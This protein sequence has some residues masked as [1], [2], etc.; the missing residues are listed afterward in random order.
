VFIPQES[1]PPDQAVD[2][3]PDLSIVIPVFNEE[4]KIDADL[5]AA[6]AYFERQP[7]TFELIVVDDGSVDHTPEKITA[8]QQ[9][10]AP[11]LRAICYQPNRG[12]GYAVRTGMLA[13]RGRSRMFTDAGL[14]VPFS[15][16][17]R[18]LAALRDGCDV[19]IGSRKL[20]ASRIVRAQ[21]AYR[22]LGSRLFGVIARRLMGLG[23]ITDTQC[24]FKLFT[25]P[26][27][28]RLFRR[29]RIDGFMFDAETLINARRLGMRIAEF[30]VQ[31]RAD[32]DSRYRPLSGSIRNLGELLRIRFF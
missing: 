24:G 4:K 23:G 12:K 5:E 27:A 10:L 13:A 25:G 11:R 20:A 22:Q 31:W 17:E 26:A 9:R 15:E 16:T 6:L 29:G 7:Y 21:P 3:Q 1:L 14:C 28:E 2:A 32:P 19:A 18:G 8:W 30:P